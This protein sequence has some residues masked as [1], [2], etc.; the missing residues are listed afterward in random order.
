MSAGADGNGFDKVEQTC[1]DT[2]KGAGEVLILAVVG[3]NRSFEKRP[4]LRRSVVPLQILERG[5]DGLVSA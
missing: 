3:E 1:S 2:I 4:P 5:N